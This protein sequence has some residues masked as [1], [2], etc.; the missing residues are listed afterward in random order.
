MSEQEQDETLR[1]IQETCNDGVAK[2]N[3]VF[4]K[5]Q[6]LLYRKYKDKKR[7]DFRANCSTI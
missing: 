2:R 6:G 1:D 7:S 5:Q 4:Y 3:V